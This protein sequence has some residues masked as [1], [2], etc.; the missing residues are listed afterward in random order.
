MFRDTDSICICLMNM[1]L[2][3]YKEP[4]FMYAIKY[5]L[6]RLIS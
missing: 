4:E 3:V 1:T 6:D 2:K 5:D